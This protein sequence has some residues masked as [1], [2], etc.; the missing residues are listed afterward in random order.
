MTYNITK[1][2][3]D[4]VQVVFNFINKSNCSSIE[5]T[6][7]CIR[8]AKAQI[9]DSENVILELSHSNFNENNNVRD[10]FVNEYY[11]F[12]EYGLTKEWMCDILNEA[13]VD[14]SILEIGKYKSFIDLCKFL[15]PLYAKRLYKIQPN[16]TIGG[17][18]YLI[19]VLFSMVSSYKIPSNNEGVSGDLELG[20]KV[21]EIK[22]NQGRL[23]GADVDCLLNVIS[24]YEEVNNGK[25]GTVFSD[26]HC[27]LVK[28]LLRCYFCGKN[29]YPIVAVNEEGYVIIDDKLEWDGVDVGI[30][31]PKW[32]KRKAFDRDGVYK[33]NDNDRTIKINLR[34]KKA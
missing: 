17:G 3:D 23:D 6:I 26:K 29:P 2:V 11:I 18:E 31:I 21:Y 27:D 30:T 14:N 16:R 8:K 4:L 20:G 1:E 15:S 5:E 32:M 19:R 9:E 24:K 34:K 13:H 7:D 10:L 25:G 22:G 12:R 28:D 33:Y